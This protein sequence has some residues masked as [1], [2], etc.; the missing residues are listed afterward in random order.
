MSVSL[1]AFMPTLDCCIVC[2]IPQE[3]KQGQ[4]LKISHDLYTLHWLHFN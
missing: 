3:P 4:E 1:L 2:F